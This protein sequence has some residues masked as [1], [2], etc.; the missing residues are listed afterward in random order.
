MGVRR[1]EAFARLLPKNGVSCV[2]VTTDRDSATALFKRPLAVENDETET[3]AIFRIPCPAPTLPRSL[4]LRRLRK[5]LAI[6]DGIGRSWDLALTAAWD[7]VLAA[8]RPNVLLVSA[9][10]FSVV[11]LAVKLAKRSRLPLIIDLRD[12]W[13]QW[14][15]S[16]YPSYIHYQLTL[17]NERSC[18][19]S[20]AAVVCTTFQTA[21]DI[22]SAHPGLAASKF[23]VI[24]NGYDIELPEAVASPQKRDGA[25]F[26]I[27]YVGSFYYDENQR[28][29]HTAPRWHLPLKH[30]AWY[31]PRR[32]D[33]LY[34]TPYFFFRSVRC[35]L[36]R[37]PNLRDKLKIR[38]VG[39]QPR[40]LTD[41]I[42]EFQLEN[43]VEVLGRISYQDSIRFQANCDALLATSAKVIGG[44]DYSIAG[45]T[46]EYVSAGRPVVAFVCEG[47]QRDFYSQ[48]GN[49][50]IFDPDD[51]E[52]SSQLLEDLVS[53]RLRF[54]LNQ[55]FLEQY[56]RDAI[57]RR[58]AEIA[59]EVGK[60]V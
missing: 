30:W 48:A 12:A 1:S 39:D 36:N 59:G 26:V 11:R 5:L 15:M 9:P 34:R 32:E 21:A 4:W 16:P 2:V 49:A 7:G 3:G 27:G 10:P 14:C 24:P 38:F 47:E 8:S 57:A 53:N 56:S 28:R 29:F 50:I 18:L 33:W 45:K 60:H 22:Q 25:P 46:F 17:A 19:A 43:I 13:S 51:V 52:G 23:H 35:L 31:S 54:E 6:D 40:W 20:A 58:L 37:V 42:A 44:R 55:R 41:Q